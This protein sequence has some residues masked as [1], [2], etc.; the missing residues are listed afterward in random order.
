MFD[1]VFLKVIRNMSEL[2]RLLCL[3]KN[4]KKKTMTYCFGLDSEFCEI[5]LGRFD[6]YTF[7]EDL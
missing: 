7:Y 3:F 2:S 4:K 1:D 6:I 5:F